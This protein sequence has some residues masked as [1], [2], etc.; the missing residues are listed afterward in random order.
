M[1]SLAWIWD[2]TWASELST[3]LSACFEWT[4]EIE[5]GFSFGLEWGLDWSVEFGWE[6]GCEYSKEYSIEY[7]STYECDWGVELNNPAV[8][9]SWPEPQ[10]VNLPERKEPESLLAPRNPSSTLLTETITAID[11]EIEER[12]LGR[13]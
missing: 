9:P 10:H 13:D 4:W 3:D 6:W 7:E 5:W 1:K 11:P 12:F 2:C 8:I